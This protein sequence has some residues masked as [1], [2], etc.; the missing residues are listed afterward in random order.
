M[1]TLLLG[2]VLGVGAVFVGAYFYFS[3]GFAPV[4]T[5]APPMPF[6]EKMA[7]MALHARIAK[8]A[9]SNVPLPA[10]ESILVAGA[11][12]Y[13][14]HCAVCHG[15]NGRPET[16]TAKGMFPKPPQFFQGHGVTDDPVGETYWKAKNGIRLTGMPAYG[17][18]LSDQQLWQVSLL[19]AHAGKLPLRAEKELSGSPAIGQSGAQN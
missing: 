2:L 5:S 14:E 4:A 15:L 8:E 19:L 7:N 11:Q 10:D 13:R 16:A 1:K 9:P 3:L 6:E 18:S 12:L 17:S